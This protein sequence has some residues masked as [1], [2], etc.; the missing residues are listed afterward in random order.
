MTRHLGNTNKTN[1]HY[2]VCFNH[3]GYKYYK[4]NIELRADLG[5][6]YK[7]IQNYLKIPEYKS[8]MYNHIQSISRCIVPIS[9]FPHLTLQ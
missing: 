7:I 8:K 3:K 1:F 2:C 6:S 5:I 9:N 4:T